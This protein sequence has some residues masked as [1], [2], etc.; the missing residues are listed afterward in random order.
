MIN[1]IIADH[2]Y[3]KNTPKKSSGCIFKNQ[4]PLLNS[5]R[6][7]ILPDHQFQDVEKFL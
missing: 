5:S 6:C 7:P 1:K 3:A 4:D 2:L